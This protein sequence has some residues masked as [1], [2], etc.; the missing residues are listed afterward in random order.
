MATARRAAR[1]DAAASRRDPA[2]DAFLADLD[3]PLKTEIEEVRG[4]VLGAAP[5][6]RDGIKWNGPSFRTTEWFAT[7]FLRSTD[8]VQLVFHLGAKV[9]DGSTKGVDVPDPEGLIR[10][11]TK[12]R[13]I[14]T[15]GAGKEIRARRAAIESIVRAW[16]AHLPSRA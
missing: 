9:K 2:V 1:A 4:I 6:I 15:A 13:C 12:E 14:V 16:I 10:W 8:R 7:V 11:I 5:A 3:H